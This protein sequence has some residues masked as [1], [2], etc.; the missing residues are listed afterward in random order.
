MDQDAFD[1]RRKELSDRV[2][3]AAKD[4][5]DFMNCAGVIT[6]IPDTNPALYLVAG[7]PRFIADEGWRLKTELQTMQVRAR[8]G[9]LKTH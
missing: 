2:S 6:P 1:A 7:S 4:L 3:T 5:L 8:R 9:R